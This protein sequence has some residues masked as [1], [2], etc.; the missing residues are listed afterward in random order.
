M[1]NPQSFLTLPPLH[2][3]GG[4]QPQKSPRII[5]IP[6]P[7]DAI[8]DPIYYCLPEWAPL[9]VLPL[10][11][12]TAPALALGRWPQLRNEFVASCRTY[13]AACCSEKNLL[14]LNIKFR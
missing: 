5:A 9:T 6:N 8:L 12:P 3:V 1:A 14:F 7:S 11:F 13:P 2:W 4:V 10:A